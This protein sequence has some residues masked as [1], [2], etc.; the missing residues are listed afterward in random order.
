MFFNHMFDCPTSSPSQVD[1]SHQQARLRGVLDL[2]T[3]GQFE[4]GILRLVREVVP[5]ILGIL[6]ANKVCNPEELI[7]NELNAQLSM[8]QSGPKRRK[9]E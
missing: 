6:R 1:S 9:E 3:T 4:G 2:T 8:I 7:A 5:E